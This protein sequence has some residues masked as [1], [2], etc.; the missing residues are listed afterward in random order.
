MEYI[1]ATAYVYGESLPQ[2]FLSPYCNL[3]EKM[4]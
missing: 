3:T 4:Q 2:M 1:R